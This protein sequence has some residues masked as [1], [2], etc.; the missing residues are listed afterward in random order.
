MFCKDANYRV[1]KR[2]GKE[3]K[4]VREENEKRRERGSRGMCEVLVLCVLASYQEDKN[5]VGATNKAFAMKCSSTI[6]NDWNV[7]KRERE[8]EKN[9][10]EEAGCW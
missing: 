9:R 6:R 2:D 10:A 5:V 1:G 7:G 8:R 4:R 3:H